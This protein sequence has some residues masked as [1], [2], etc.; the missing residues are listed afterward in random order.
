VQDGNAHDLRL[1]TLPVTSQSDRQSKVSHQCRSGRILP[2]RLLIGTEAE[3]P[4][5]KRLK[6]AERNAFS[7]FH[8]PLSIIFQESGSSVTALCKIM[9][10]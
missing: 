3:K 2:S 7:I 9:E 6:Q 8:F 4:E 10:N 1:R 5:G